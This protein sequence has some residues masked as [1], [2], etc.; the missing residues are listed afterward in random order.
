M[1]ADDLVS[2][3]QAMPDG[4]RRASLVLEDAQFLAALPRAASPKH[5][6]D[7][8]RAQRAAGVRVSRFSSLRGTSQCASSSSKRRCSS[9]LNRS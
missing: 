7:W 5:E 1:A 9:F 8:P 4:T 6:A 2:V 3:E